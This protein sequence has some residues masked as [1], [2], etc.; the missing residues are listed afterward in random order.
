MSRLVTIDCT[1]NEIRIAVGTK[2]LTG[3]SLEHVVCCPL[4]LDENEELISSPKTLDAIQS[5]LKK[6]GVKSGDAIVCVGRGSIE[7]RALTLPTVDRNELPDMVRFAAQRHFAN[8]GDNWPIDYV[9][10]PSSQENMTECLA[11]SMNPVLIDRVHKVLE[12]CGLTLTQLVL[13]PMASATMAVVKQPQ[14][15]SSV[16]LLVDLFRDEADMAVTENGHVVFMRNVRFSTSSNPASNQQVLTGEIKRTMIAAASQ[17]PDLNVQQIRIWGQESQHAELCSS[18]SKSLSVPVSSLDPFQ[19]FD[20]SPSVRTEAGD[21]FG[22]YAA[23]LGALL[24]PQVSDRLIDFS[25]PRKRIEKSQPILLYALAGTAAAALLLGGFAWYWMSHSALDAEIAQLNTV[26]TA[27][28]ETIKLTT[29]KVSD[30]NKVEKFLKGDH[31][32]LDELDYI[33]S[34]AGDP[35]KAMFNSATFNTDVLTGASTISSKFVSTEQEYV[36]VLRAGFS[37]STHTVSGKNVTPSQD[38][39]NQQFPW[40]G[41]LLI[42]MPPVAVADPRKSE[43][44]PKERDA[45]FDRNS[46][47]SE[48]VTENKGDKPGDTP[49]ASAAVEPNKVE[50]P[51]TEPNKV[52]PKKIEPAADAPNKV[53]PSAVEPNKVEPPAVEPNKVEPNKVEPASVEPNKVEPAAV[54]PNKEVAPSPGSTPATTKEVGV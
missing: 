9:T 51:E 7:L 54:E 6:V 31:Q 10:M 8:V 49:A 35:S 16:V 47:R 33:S 26:I 15:A 43:S 12:T 3:V 24:A 25:N 2:G 30:W 13:R 48:P 27:N 19:L 11:A 18:L 5:L 42:K 53:E 22:K 36:P 32:W 14:L 38:R 23:T 28:E 21:D 50:L 20:V 52:E 44:K 46:K 45:S 39:T 17:R 4:L 29:K 41:D 37:D 1:A 34:K 40:G